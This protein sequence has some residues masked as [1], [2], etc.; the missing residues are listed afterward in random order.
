MYSILQRKYKSTDVQ[1]NKNKKVTDGK[2]LQ[3]NMI[4]ILYAHPRGITGESLN[5]P[6]ETIYFVL[7]HFCKPFDLLFFGYSRKSLFRNDNDDSVTHAIYAW[8]YS[9]QTIYNIFIMF[10][11]P[12]FSL[13]SITTRSCYYRNSLSFK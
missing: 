4:I 11:P 3:Y 12:F 8:T 5:P 1:K 13:N 7:K 2:I 9:L 10:R 6:R